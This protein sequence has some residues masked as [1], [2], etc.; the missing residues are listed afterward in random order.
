MG[1]SSLTQ[2]HRANR[3]KGG[4]QQIRNH[5]STFPFVSRKAQE[6][7]IVILNSLQLVG[8]IFA[9]LLGLAFGSC[10]N[11][12]LTRFPEG[13]SIVTPR[14]HCR[15]CE[16]TL[17][18]WENLPLLSWIML[19]GRC[20]SCRA[21]IGLRYPFIEL[22]VGL[23]WAACWIRF[24]QPLF[25]PD[26]APG[27]TI[28]HPAIQSLIQ[29]AGS[30]VLVWLLIALA[31]LDA[32]HFWL[33]DWLTLPGIAAGF[34]FTLLQAWARDIQS[35]QV[36]RFVQFV[37]AGNL[38][39]AAWHALI[40]I[41]ASAGLI[42]ILRLG[43]WLVRRREG[44]GLGDAKLMALLAAW[45]GFRGAMESFFFAIL[46]ATAAAILWLAILA[47]RRDT[48]KWA[49]MPLPLGTFLCVAGLLEIFCPQ[50]LLNS[51]RL[52]F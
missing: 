21:W 49:Q 30:A 33:P 19:R 1:A 12:F 48:G 37:Q 16:Q 9:A 29:V 26:L 42:L 51:Q 25:A 5:L 8:T 47:T 15:H 38:L 14:S 4:N 23:L 18:W 50:W 41:L 31:A 13:E 43:Y 11:V 28:L 36:V 52:G 2:S 45:F 22:A 17:T 40:A 34:L 35:V 44:I 7:E 6:S 20:R 32:E 27:L 24:G 3:V 39:H 10:L 46:V